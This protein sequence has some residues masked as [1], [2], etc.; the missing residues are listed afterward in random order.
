MSLKTRA[1]I[2]RAARD[3]VP[4]WPLNSFIAVNP[5]GGYES[6]DF[7]SVQVPGVVTT[8]PLTAYRADIDSGRIT[9][10]DLLAAVHERIPELR[11][12]PVSV[13]SATISAAELLV[14]ELTDPTP[15]TVSP[16]TPSEQHDLV[17]DIT[18][19][20]VA[21]FLDPDPLWRIPRR[22]DGFYA[23]WRHLATHDPDLPGAARRT[24]RRLPT[25]P[26]DAVAS[27]MT[28]LEVP[29]RDED[30]ILR[31][32]LAGLPGWAAHIKW[33]SEHVG[34][35][36][37]VDYLAVRLSLRML[38]AHSS[39]SAALSTSEEVAT[40]G[41]RDLWPR[42]VRVAERLGVGTDRKTVAIIGRVLAFHPLRDH[43][44]TLQ[45][46]YEVHYARTLVLP[47]G[48]S[49]PA[50]SLPHL[51]LVACIDPRSEGI[52]RHLERLDPRIETF[53]FAGFFGVPVRF[54][55][56]NSPSSIDSL[57]AL[58]SAHHHITEVPQ[59]AGDAASYTKGLRTRQAFAAG[60]HT[61][62]S[63]TVSPFAF[64]EATGWLFGVSTALRTFAPTTAAK[65]IATLT[66]RPSLESSVT[67]VE[68][69]SLQERVR[70]AEAS[71]RMMGLYRFAPLVVLAGH[72]STSA[73]NLYKSALDCGACGGNRGDVNA[74]AAATILNDPDVRALLSEK[75]LNIPVDT[76]FLAAEHDTVTDRISTFD[77]HLIPETHRKLVDDFDRL[78]GAASDA[79]IRERAQS[80]PGASPW[81]ATKKTRRR[82]DDWAEVYPEW[83]L[84]GNAA[85]IIGPREL[86][87]ALDLERRVFLHSYRPELDPKGAALETILT[88]PVVVAQWINHQYYFSALNPETL[89]AGTKTTHN[90][91]GTLGVLSGQRGD[92]RRGLPW[93]SLGVGD[94]LVHEPM[95]LAVIVQAPLKH[96]IE[97]IGRNTVLQNLFNNN[98]ISLTAREDA[99][100][101]WYLYGR[102]GW[103]S[104]HHNTTPTSE[105]TPS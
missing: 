21:A 39:G 92:L 65:W 14:A 101:P 4:Q 80:L 94:R 89:G 57:P 88:A 64:A 26:E 29:A 98:W 48:N 15:T 54:S 44:Y 84:V 103:S 45:R 8:R 90:A 35:V 59:D 42:A 27:A 86:T 6:T 18:S 16:T 2:A 70:L 5:L 9:P 32:E 62:E 1:D 13:G 102:Y 71:L 67:V 85:F 36:D 19:K 41:R 73:N 96:I 38:L 17:D 52:R 10:E 87:R 83:G 55:T 105:G 99:S 78:Q 3:I 37:L 69:F 60:I 49:E 12:R 24:A 76:F 34:D 20:W 40:D 46:A 68:A 77:T 23:A 72:G 82:A 43:P 100:S 75:E 104:S 91:I 66:S 79:L 31:R 81:H 25:R 22:R 58:L 93:Q 11:S 53:G 50:D 7:E 51:Q 30:S 33:R 56:Y 28:G 47:L 97:I 74:R 63:T 61:G 95:R